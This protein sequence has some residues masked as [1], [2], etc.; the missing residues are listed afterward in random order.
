MYP[1]FTVRPEEHDLLVRGSHSYDF[2]DGFIHLF[3]HNVAL[4]LCL[5]AGSIADVVASMDRDGD[6]EGNKDKHDVI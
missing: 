6:D 3:L 2:Y 4:W 1:P 5:D